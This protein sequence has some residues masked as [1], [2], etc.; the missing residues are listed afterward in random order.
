MSDILVIKCNAI[1]K[2]ERLEDMRRLFHL[3]RMCKEH[4]PGIYERWT[5]ATQQTA[6]LNDAYIRGFQD[7]V[8]NEHDRIMNI[9]DGEKT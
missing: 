8:I 9:L 3:I 5:T 4:G 1:V 7:G 2:P 6:Y